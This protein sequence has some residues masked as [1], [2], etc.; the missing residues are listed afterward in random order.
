MK[1]AAIINNL[2]SG[3]AERLIVDLARSF[4]VLPEVTFDVILL[5]R[6]GSVHIEA[7]ER[8]GVHVI[9]LSEASSRFNPLFLFQ[10]TKRLKTYDLVHAHLFPTQYWVVL[11]SMFLPKLKLVVTTHNDTNR[12]M[13]RPYR[14]VERFMWS[15]YDSVIAI[16]ERARVALLDWL[17]ELAS[18]TVVIENGVDTSRFRTAQMVSRSS[19]GFSDGDYLVQMTAR[20]SYEK[21]HETLFKAMAILPRKYKLILLGEG[22][23]IDEAKALCEQLG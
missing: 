23:G 19:L 17:P 4:S 11:A 1:I 16:S 7:L 21:D 6:K 8:E 5:A 18:R 10:L 13:R 12:R 3:G 14:L 9:A 20:F 22:S 2:G 15:R